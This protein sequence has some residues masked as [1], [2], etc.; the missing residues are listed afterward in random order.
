MSHP[1]ALVR[2]YNPDVGFQLTGD[3]TFPMRARPI[4]TDG[5]SYC[6]H[7]CCEQSDDALQPAGVYLS[8]ETLK[9]VEGSVDIEITQEMVG[10]AIAISVSPS[11]IFSSEII[12]LAHRNK[13]PIR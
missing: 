4:W 7:A 10:K 9:E 12:D 8:I 3:T 13:V 5:K 6:D 11:A 2:F 1:A